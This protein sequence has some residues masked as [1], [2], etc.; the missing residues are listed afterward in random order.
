LDPFLGAGRNPDIE[1]HTV[2]IFI[3]RLQKYFEDNPTNPVYIKGIRGAWYTFA[4][5]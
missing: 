3:A 5:E 2:D 1:T 4:A